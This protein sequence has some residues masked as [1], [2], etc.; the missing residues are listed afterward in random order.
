MNYNKSLI[1][2]YNFPVLR[3]K[4]PSTTRSPI[5][6]NQ[7]THIDLSDE[8]EERKDGGEYSVN[9]VPMEFADVYIPKVITNTQYT[10]V[11]IT[12]LNFPEDLLLCHHF[13]SAHLDKN[14]N[15]QCPENEDGIRWIYVCWLVRYDWRSR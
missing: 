13:A 11:S 7:P 15:H 10:L 3:E 5:V 1:S 8:P 6:T 9:D 4:T 12:W 2:T 14:R